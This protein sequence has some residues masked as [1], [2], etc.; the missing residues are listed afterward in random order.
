MGEWVGGFVIKKNVV[1]FLCGIH[2]G[3]AFND[4]YGHMNGLRASFYRPL[5]R[6]RSISRG[7]FSL[8]AKDL[9]PCSLWRS[10]VY[11]QCS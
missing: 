6:R 4:P 3:D 11:L 1:F 8:Q 9:C 7:R 10:L 5:P 2:H